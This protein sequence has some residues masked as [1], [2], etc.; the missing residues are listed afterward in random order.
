V[1]SALTIYGATGYVGEYVARTAD[2][3]GVKAIVAGRD[4][5]KLDRIASETG[6]ERRTFGLDDPALIDSA[7][8]RVAVVL[9]C[10]G[11]FKYAA[12]PLVEACLR[13]G[14][15]YLDLTGEIPVYEALQARDEQA[16]ARGVMLLPGVG[17]DIVPTDCLALHLKQRLPSATQLRLGFQSVGS[18]GLPSGTQRTAIKLLNYGDRVRRNGKLVRPQTGGGT[19]LVDFGT[20]TIDAVRVPWGDVFTAYYSTGIPNIEDYVAAPAS[21]LRRMA[22]GRAIAP[23]L[24]SRRSA[25]S[26]SW[27]CAPVRA[28]SFGRGPQRTSGAKSQTNTGI[29]P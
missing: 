21:L 25:F 5:V 9:N 20:G 3:L 11:P 24:N 29:A 1:P 8:N 19:I 28:Q 16:K 22:F 12:E 6:L 15:H 18:A 26:C 13:S 27:Q 4:A 23:C 14:A 10:A 2:R 17:F 7:L